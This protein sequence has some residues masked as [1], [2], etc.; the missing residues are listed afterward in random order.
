MKQSSLLKFV[1]K[2]RRVQPKE[3][4]NSEV[5]EP[6]ISSS[7]ELSSSASVHSPITPSP[8]ALHSPASTSP[9]HQ[10]TGTYGF[11]WLEYSTSRDAV[12]CK[13]CR[14]FPE[15]A[16]ESRFIKN[17]FRDWKHLSHCCVKHEASRAHATALG[18]SEGYKAS[19]KPERGNIIN[20]LHK[21]AVN[22]SFVERNREHIKVVI[23]LILFYAKQDI[24]LHGHRENEEAL[25][26][27]NF[28]E[29]FQL[30][31]S[32]H[33]EIK[34][35]LDELP[36]NA[37]LTSPNIQNEMLEIAALLN[38]CKIKAD[39]HDETDTYYAILADECKD[40]SKKE[41]VAVCIRYIH[42]GQLKERAVG[43]VETGD[44]STS[45]ISAKI[46]EVLEPLQLD[47][48]LCVGFGFDGASV[49]SGKKGGVH[50]ILKKTFPHAVYVHCNSHRLNL[51]LCTASKVSPCISKCFDVIN[52]LHSFMTGSHRHARFMQ[53]HSCDVRWS[54]WSMLTLLGPILETLAEFSESSGHSK[55]EADSLLH[56]MQTEK[57]LFLLVTFN[58][59]FEMSDYA[60]KDLQSAT[61]SVTDCIDLIEGLKEIYTTFR[62][63]E[64]YL[65]KAMA[66][67]EDLMKR[68]GIVNWDITGTR[69]R[70]LTAKLGDTLIEST[71]GKAS[72][73]KDNSDL[74]QLWN[75]IVD[76]KIME[77]NTRF[78]ADTYR[79]MRAAAACLP[80]SNTFG[81]THF[82]NTVED[83]EHEVF[84]QQL[85]RKI[86]NGRA[87]PSLV[88][89]LDTCPHDIFPRMKRLLRALITIPITSCGVKRLFST[90]YR[91]KTGIRATMLT[92]RL[93]SL[94]LLSFE[95]ELTE[96]LDYNKIIAVFNSKPRR[97]LL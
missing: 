90:V 42:K 18:R 73:V 65:D 80:Q 6:S 20:Q 57:F 68:H 24:P 75:D 52:N 1:S 36:R 32:H 5:Q 56:Q 58:K 67:T 39:L 37:K 61:I 77:L 44:M 29:L 4:D 87:F 13:P 70:K 22:S 97:L 59:L 66:L 12:F 7:N 47:P 21:D 11:P 3:E 15:A 19:H 35:R 76:K 51:V 43:F 10:C 95:R 16:T 50:V 30:I 81:N 54:S 62:N 38:L 74:K 48:N 93:K 85:E 46:L 41:L 40:L 91:I 92:Q 78:K 8:A 45:A 53:I 69:K 94:S 63:E 27:G 28:L 9:T 25:N 26:K 83:S 72:P 86:S 88:E 71:V 96:L 17:G 82:N 2:R 89:V 14:H 60:T 64:N 33:P 34:K 84:V 55:L 23:D 79:L 31:S 49:M